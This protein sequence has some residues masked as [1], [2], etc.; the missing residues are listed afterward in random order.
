MRRNAF[1]EEEFKKYFGF[2]S[3]AGYINCICQMRH[4]KI[5]YKSS[6]EYKLFLSNAALVM[7]LIKQLYKSSGEYGIPVKC[8]IVV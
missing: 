1:T 5:L 3:P 4:C 8:G 6:G 2:V 7:L